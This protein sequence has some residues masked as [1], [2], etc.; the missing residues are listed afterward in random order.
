MSPYSS[1]ILFLSASLIF[2]ITT[3]LAVE[4]ATLPK[5]FG[6]TSVSIVSPISSVLS[7]FLASL[8]LISVS[9]LKKDGTSFLGGS[10]PSTIAFSFSSSSFSSSS[11]VSLS[12]SVA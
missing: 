2:W 3:C 8:N 4:A 12:S 7:I 9:G 10:F 1:I 11:L 6:V 5:S